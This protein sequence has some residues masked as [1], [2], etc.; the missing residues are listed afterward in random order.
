MVLQGGVFYF[1]FA[2]AE[3]PLSEYNRN[4]NSWHG[5]EGNELLEHSEIGFA[6]A[7][8]YIINGGKPNIRPENMHPVDAS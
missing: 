4:R 7:F 5:N 1:Y 2:L 3:R 6:D 8:D